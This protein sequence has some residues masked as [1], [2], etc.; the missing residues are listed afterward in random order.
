[1]DFLRTYYVWGTMLGARVAR[2]DRA[3]KVIV[4]MEVTFWR[5]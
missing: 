1:M 5:M 4:I 2:M 3:D